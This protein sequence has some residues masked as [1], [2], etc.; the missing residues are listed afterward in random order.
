MSRPGYLDAPIVVPAHRPAWPPAV[1]LFVA[2]VAA[3]ALLSPAILGL[4]WEILLPK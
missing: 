4:Y 3:L 2:F 1:K